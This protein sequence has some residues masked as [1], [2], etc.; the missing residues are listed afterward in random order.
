MAIYVSKGKSSIDEILN[1]D[2]MFVLKGGEA[3]LGLWR[4]KCVFL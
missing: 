2:S 4:K 1:N 3:F